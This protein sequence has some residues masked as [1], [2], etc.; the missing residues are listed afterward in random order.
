[1]ICMYIVIICRICF[2]FQ[3]PRAGRGVNT[4]PPSSEILILY[5]LFMN[6]LFESL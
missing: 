6:K 4:T 3:P 2:Q 1:M 5:F